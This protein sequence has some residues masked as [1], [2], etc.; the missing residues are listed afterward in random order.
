MQNKFTDVKTWTERLFPELAAML[1]AAVI[2]KR[3][4]PGSR[5]G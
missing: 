2:A 4:P 5:S 3:L 1:F